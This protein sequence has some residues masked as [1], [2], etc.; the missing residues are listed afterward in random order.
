[1]DYS[2][3]DGTVSSVYPLHVSVTSDSVIWH[4]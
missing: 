2:F 4:R 3:P 1:M